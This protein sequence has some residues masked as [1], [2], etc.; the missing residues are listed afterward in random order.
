MKVDESIYNADQHIYKN[1]KN[2]DLDKR[3]WVSQNILGHLRT[4]VESIALKIS[5][6]GANVEMK[7]DDIQLALKYIKSNGKVNFLNKFHELLQKSASHYI[8]SEEGSERLILKYYEYLLKIKNFL[9]EKYNMEVLINIEDF[10]I[11]VDSQLK[12]FHEKIVEKI[13]LKDTYTNFDDRYYISKIKPFFINNQIYYEVTFTP[14]TEYAS[15]F[16]RMIAFTKLDILHN[17]AAKL[18][19]RTE[20]INVFGN[21]IEIL[22]IDKWEVSIRPCELKNFSEIL[23]LNYKIQSSH[24]DYRKLMKFLTRSRLSLVD[25][26][27]LSDYEFNQYTMEIS[28]DNKSKQIIEVLNKSR[29]IIIANKPGANILRYLLYKMNNKVIKSQYSWDKCYILTNLNLQFGCIPFDEMPFATSLKNHNPNLYDL[30]ECIENKDRE[31]EFLARYIKNKAEKEGKIYTAINEIENF[32]DI[33]ILIEK[34]NELLYKKHKE[35]SLKKFKDFV[36]IQKYEEDVFNILK[37]LLKLTE[38]GI[39]DYNLIVKEWKEEY[40]Y[41][42]DC[43]KKNDMIDVMFEK[44]KVALIYGAAGTGKSTMV[45]HIS[46]L[47]EDKQKLFLANTNPAV[48]NLKSKVTAENVGFATIAKYL[49]NFTYNHRYYDVIIIDECSTVSNKDF[50]QIIK[51][52]NFDLLVL[53]GDVYQIDSIIFGNWFDLAKEFIQSNSVFELLIPY[54]TTDENLIQLWKKVREL[55]DDIQEHMAKNSYSTRL[56]SSIFNE[57]SN[58]EIILCLNY[59]GLYG[60]NNLNRILQANNKGKLY[61]WGVYSYKINDPILFNE[62][63]RFSPVLYNNLKG[64]IVDIESDDFSITFTVEIEKNITES[65]ALSQNLIWVSITEQGNTMLKFKVNKYSNSDDDEKSLDTVIPFQVSYAISIYKAQGLE[66]DSVKIIITDEIGE[67][68]TH[69]I[70][71]TAITRARK[72]LKIYWSPETENKILSSY[73]KRKK[74]R[75]IYLLKRLLV[76]V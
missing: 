54:R 25:L 67:L 46:K 12:E 36:Y 28:N 72:E 34:Y 48:E 11:K 59:D 15:K 75:D 39:N 16:D 7:Y 2:N 56:N 27:T 74:N 17:Y 8:L 37:N 41:E 5:A 71:Y 20:V 43:Q 3:G 4:F 10:P 63:N 42:I 60:I 62:S 30:F 44:S 31:H 65:E 45:N 70:F 50:I 14:P 68:I 22:I 19:I 40:N 21:E 66:F 73:E 6:N 64:K 69:N 52:A 58:D 57:T 35:R 23:G 33:N 24:S 1:I 9:D 51:K 26:V 32:S 29:E 13:N 76:E 49:N 61:K 55:D 38:Q 53:V 18:A 47:F